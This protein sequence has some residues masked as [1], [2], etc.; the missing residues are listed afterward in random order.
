MVLFIERL[1]QR[2]LTYERRF[3]E[4]CRRYS[5]YIN[6][7]IKDEKVD[8]SYNI[9]PSLMYKNKWKDTGLRSSHGPVFINYLF[10]VFFLSLYTFSE[11]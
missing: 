7:L 2:T 8:L 3:K 10:T 11:S 6:K 1:S 4:Q 9:H 5:K